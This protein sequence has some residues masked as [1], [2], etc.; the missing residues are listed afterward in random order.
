[1][2]SFSQE[3]ISNSNSKDISQ[4]NNENKINKSLKEKYKIVPEH[5]PLEFYSL[6]KKLMSKYKILANRN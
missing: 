1:M 3:N 4:I 2:S 6:G 5:H